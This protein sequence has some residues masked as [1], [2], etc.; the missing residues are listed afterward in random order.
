MKIHTNNN[1]FF[2][3]IGL[4]RSG[5]TLLSNIFNSYDNSFSLVEPKWAKDYNDDYFTTD[6]ISM[7]LDCDLVDFVDRLVKIEGKYNVGC[8]KETF[9]LHQKEYTDYLI[10]D[11]RFDSIIF[12]FREPISNFSSWKRTKWGSYYDD[13][14]YFIECYSTL[15]QTYLNQKNKYLIIYENICLNGS[16][17]L[18]SIFTGLKFDNIE[19]I[20]STNFKFGDEGANSG[21]NIKS[22]SFNDENITIVEKEKINTSLKKI[23]DLLNESFYN[24]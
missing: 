24:N 2:G 1:L 21:G 5:T 20:K 8:I 19:K 13:V 17:Y 23:Y 16:T 4:P 18:N 15:Y 11:N 12:I 3:I 10:D 9:R 7:N 6:K 22:P 14:D